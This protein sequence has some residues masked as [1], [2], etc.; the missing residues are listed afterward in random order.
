MKLVDKPNLPKEIFDQPVA[1]EMLAQAVRVHLA[2]QRQGNQNAKTR[3]EI[4][5]TRKKLYKQKGTGGAR[6]GDRKAPIFVGGGIAFAPKPRDHSLSLPVKMK[7]KAILGALTDKSKEKS[8]LVFSGMSTLSGKTVE[9]AS[10]LKTV[11]IDPSKK[12]QNLLILTDVHREN[13]LRAARNI[14]G[15]TVIPVTLINP[16]EIIKA[17]KILLMDEAVETIGTQPEVKVKVEVEKVQKSEKSTVKATKTAPT[18]T[19]VA[20]KKVVKKAV[21][22]A[23]K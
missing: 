23:K 19:K 2:N 10:F 11:E 12:H 7:R 4:A 15:V 22:S 5:R 18:K 17:D 16:F 1:P 21:K 13:V 20:T 14:S 6:H 3:A 9:L 8:V